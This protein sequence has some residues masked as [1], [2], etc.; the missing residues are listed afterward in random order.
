[1][2]AQGFYSATDAAENVQSYY[3][4][5]RATGLAT[6]PFWDSLRNPVGFEGD[7]AS[8][9]K[10][11][12]RPG[13]TVGESNVYG[14]GSQRAT[15]TKWPT[16]E[17]MNHL[18]IMK[19]TSGF[20]GSQLEAY[21]ITKQKAKLQEQKDQ[22]RKQI[23]LDSELAMLKDAAPV[24]D[25]DA[26]GNRK[27]SMAGAKHFA[28]IIIDAANIDEFDFKK[29]ISDP[30]KH[31]WKSGVHEDK[32]IMPGIEVKD[33]INGV[34]DDKKQTG[35][36]EKKVVRNVTHVQDS[37]WGTN[38]PI[39]PNMSL[40]DNELIIYAPDLINPVVLRAIKDRECSDPTYDGVAYEDVFEHTIQVIDPNAIIWVKNIKLP[41]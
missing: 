13:A 27:N 39:V 4:V 12:F 19:R 29:H 9:H 2:A 20:T 40:A 25:T 41:A 31:M 16:T 33:V 7:P 24:V 8:G 14:E 22:N 17:L 3:N 35:N 34:L 6:C 21:T 28:G 38:I 11:Q 23:R 10:W 18:Q 30:L 36:N 26:D 32:I 1:M 5:I 15:I 37:G